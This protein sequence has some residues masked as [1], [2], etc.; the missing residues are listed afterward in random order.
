MSRIISFEGVDGGPVAELAENY[1]LVTTGGTDLPDDVDVSQVRAVIVRNRTLVDEQ[2]LARLPSLQIVARA[3]V[4]LDNI[5][6]AAARGRGIT[7]VSPR[8]AN[9]QSVAE[10]TL[11][12]ALTVAR[13]LLPLDDSTR[14]GE[15]ERRPGLELAGRT[16]GLLGAGATGVAAGRM[17]RAIGMEVIAHDPFA[18]PEVLRGHGIDLLPLREMV[19]RADVLSCH[20]PATDETKGVVDRRLLS[21][22][23]RGAILVNTGRGEVVDEEALVEA[24]ASGRLTGAGLD[25][26]AVEP[27][28]TGALERQDNVVLTPHIAGITQESQ[29]RILSALAHDIKAVLSGAPV[30][31]AVEQVHQ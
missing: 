22:L 8:G 7:V 10:L 13:R 18:P 23:P 19:A 30:R 25:V 28:A 9:A 3:G 11:A 27:P 2:F 26:R 1:S 31:H 17:A 15:W 16:W 6:L 5:D 21:L 12:L 20:L 29:H 14:R 24:L 4:G